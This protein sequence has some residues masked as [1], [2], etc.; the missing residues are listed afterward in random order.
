MLTMKSKNMFAALM[1]LSS[2]TVFHTLAQ[3]PLSHL[4]VSLSPQLSEKSCK[5][6]IDNL[7]NRLTETSR[8]LHN[9]TGL[10]FEKVTVVLPSFWY[11][12]NCSSNLP[13]SSISSASSSPD[14][15]LSEEDRN[16]ISVVQFGSC[17]E[18]AKHIYLPANAL[19]NS[20]DSFFDAILNY[21]F[22]VFTSNN[23][24]YDVRFPETYKIGEKEFTNCELCNFEE[25]CYDSAAPTKQNLLCGEK[26]PLSV[27]KSNVELDEKAFLVPTVEYVISET[28]RYILVLD[29]SLQAESLW[30]NLH[31]ALYR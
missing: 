21:Q 23:Q 11:H 5:F 13:L 28:T 6:L 17:G 12:S 16:S 22:G 14:I 3:Q 7:E 27:I 29:R 19:N 30:K 20:S 24:M 9:M 10:Q 26:S 8:M 18:K 31:N 25:S 4:T 15:I 1:I 2:M